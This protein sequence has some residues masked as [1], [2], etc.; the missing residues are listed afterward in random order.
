TIR[1]GISIYFPLF[2]GQISPNKLNATYQNVLRLLS[3]EGVSEEKVHAL[4]QQVKNTIDSNGNNLEELHRMR[5]EAAV[6]ESKIDYDLWCNHIA[7][8][9]LQCATLSDPSSIGTALENVQEAHAHAQKHHS[10]QSQQNT[11]IDTNINTNTSTQFPILEPNANEQ[12]LLNC[13]PLHKDAMKNDDMSP[14][15]MMSKTDNGSHIF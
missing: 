1:N 4:L 14:P 13:N 6:I 10:Q 9:L 2:R 3:Y 11:N 7:H 15:Q 5:R 12:M 8:R